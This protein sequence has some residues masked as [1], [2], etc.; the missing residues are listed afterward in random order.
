MPWP[1]RLTTASQPSTASCHLPG[2][3]RIARDDLE[4][5]HLGLAP[6]G[7][8]VPGQDHRLVARDSRAIGQVA[9]DQARTLPR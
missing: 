4:R 2:V 6:D 5:P 1:A 3:R 8:G 9:A 7:V